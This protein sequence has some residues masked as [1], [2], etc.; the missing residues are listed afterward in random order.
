MRFIFNEFDFPIYRMCFILALIAG[1]TCIY[2]TLKKEG[3]EKNIIT[4]VLLFG[5]I[6]SLIGGKIFTIITSPNSDLNIF[7]ASFSSYGGAIGLIISAIILNKVYRKRERELM[8]AHILSLPIIYAICKVGCFFVGCCY[9]IPYDGIFSVSYIYTNDIFP[10]CPA[11]IYTNGP[12]FPI[13]LV[14]AITFILIFILCLKIYT[15]KSTK[16]YTNS[17]VLGLVGIVK[18]S[19]DYLRT[20]HIGIVLSAN[21]WVSIFFVL[22]A[23][24]LLF[25]EKKQALLAEEQR[26]LQV[27][28]K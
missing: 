12:Y 4:F 3:F 11:E 2:K 5:G 16:K 10:F 15:N 14:E 20:S 25:L 23:I 17:V 24:I 28:I 18:F 13:Q 7:T 21:Q 6:F 22:F 26:E 8:M 9:G 19:L 27:D 1:G